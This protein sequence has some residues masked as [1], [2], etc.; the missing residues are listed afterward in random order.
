MSKADPNILR[1][2]EPC[3]QKK[4]AG[5][6]LHRVSGEED[7][8]EGYCGARAGLLC[9]VWRRAL[10]H[11]LAALE[12]AVPHRAVE[13]DRG[14]LEALVEIQVERPVVDHA[15]HLQAARRPDE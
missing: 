12:L 14:L 7:R 2:V 9:F 6:A 10:D 5:V 4:T 3:Q 1:T 11:V 13:I 15:A 8:G